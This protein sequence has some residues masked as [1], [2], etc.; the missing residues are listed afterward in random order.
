MSAWP[1]PSQR[2]PRGAAGCLCPTLGVRLPNWTLASKS[3]QPSRRAAGHHGPVCHLLRAGD[4]RSPHQ[5]SPGVLCWRLARVATQLGCVGWWHWCWNVGSKAAPGQLPLA[6]RQICRT[7][8]CPRR[9]A[10]QVCAPLVL[11]EVRCCA[12]LRCAVVWCAVPCWA[13][14]CCAVLRRQSHRQ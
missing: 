6:R 11:E 4:Q 2:S 5:P 8:C 3:S 1:V 14:L 7:A 12:A 9:P 10:G 13:V